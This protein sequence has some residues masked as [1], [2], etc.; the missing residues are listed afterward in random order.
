MIYGLSAEFC[1]GFWPHK[2]IRVKPLGNK[3]RELTG[4]LELKFRAWNQW[5]W[6]GF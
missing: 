1:G 4:G 5:S 2:S 3:N 6:C